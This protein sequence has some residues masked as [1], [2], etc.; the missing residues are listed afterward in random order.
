MNN[1]CDKHR[2]FWLY[3]D[4]F[5][6]LQKREVALARSEIAQARRGQARSLWLFHGLFCSPLVFYLC[7]RGAIMDIHELI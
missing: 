5:L 1:R 7:C 4:L 3:R 6:R 2:P